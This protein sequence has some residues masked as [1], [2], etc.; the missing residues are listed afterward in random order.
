M[1]TLLTKDGRAI[2]KALN[3][4]QTRECGYADLVDKIRADMDE[5]QKVKPMKCASKHFVHIITG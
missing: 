1:D 5:M 2:M 3:I 4:L